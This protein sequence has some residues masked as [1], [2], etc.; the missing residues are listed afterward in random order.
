[1]PDFTVTSVRSGQKPELGRLSE[2]A[3]AEG[4][5]FV[6]RAHDAWRRGGNRFDRPGEGFFVA[7]AIDEVVGMCGLNI[8]PY[9]DGPS[10]GRLRHLYV[11]PEARRRGVGRRLVMACLDLANGHFLRVRLRTFEADAIRL[12]ESMGFRRI[13]E[14]DATHTLEL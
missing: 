4:F 5:H 9:L 10:V 13:D 1:M 11:A 6:K 12:Y 3:A 8:D 7:L 2:S 14:P